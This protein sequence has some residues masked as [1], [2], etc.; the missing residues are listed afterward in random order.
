MAATVPSSTE[1]IVTLDLKPRNAALLER[2]AAR[3]SG[4]PPLD[5]ARIAQLFYPTADQV[6]AVR[7]AMAARGFRFVSRHGLAMRFAG[8]PAKTARAFGTAKAAPN[9]IAGLV[10]DVEGLGDT[11]PLR[12]QAVSAPHAVTPSCTG[13][14]ELHAADG[15]YLPAELGSAGAYGHNALINAGYDGE[16]ERMAFV[17]FSN[18]LPADV[19]A[20]QSCF[21]LSVPVTDVPVAGGT[22]ERHSA[23]EVSLDVETALSAAPRLDHAYVY[24]APRTLSMA[25]VI[26]QIVADQPSTGVHVVSISWGLCETL[27]T[28]SRV[29]ATNAALQLAAV[30]GMTVLVGSGDQGSLDCGL[31]PLAVDD[32]GSQPYATSVGGTSLYLNRTGPQREVAWNDAFGA[33]GGGIS[34]YWAKPTWQSGPG[35]VNGFSSGTPCRRASGVCRE[36]PDVS[37]NATAGARGYIVHCTAGD[38]F[39]QGWLLTGGTSASA[40]LMAGIVADANE[41]SR[42]HGGGRMGFANPFLYATFRDGGSVFRDITLGDNSLGPDGRYPATAGYDLATGI[43]SVDAPGMAAALAAYSASSPTLRPTTLTATPAGPRTVLY[44][45]PVVFSGELRG[46]SSPLPGQV[47]YLQGVDQLGFRSW[48]TTTDEHGRWSIT[49]GRQITRKFEWRAVYPGSERREPASARGSVVRVIPR[50]TIG[51]S[52]PLIAGRHTGRAGVPFVMS[53]STRPRMILRTVVVWARPLG[54]VRWVK[55]GPAMTGGLGRARRPVVLPRPGLW[56]VRW[57]FG[58]GGMNGQWLST[59]SPILTVS[60]TL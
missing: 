49:L 40:P 4:R 1:Q 37:L 11:P 22:T 43:G 38:C 24:I 6:A 35:V 25:S 26:N 51:T 14:N 10:A 27:L 21:G 42:A 34:R 16:G 58:G 48:R 55:L 31:P 17:E 47:V 28:P 15:G 13:A 39:R 41:Y 3:S 2:I 44:G 20:Y 50:M 53:T 8:A 18:Y 9:P 19:A 12:P 46:P 30:A 54:A 45:R 59:A 32:P 56:Q 36:V 60:M 33:G 23:L 7:S 57:R 29:A 5:A 52:L